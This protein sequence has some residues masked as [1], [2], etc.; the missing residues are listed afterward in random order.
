MLKK[1]ICFFKGH[2]PKTYWYW[3]DVS[4][5]TGEYLYKEKVYWSECDRCKKNLGIILK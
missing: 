5:T 1:I 4:A 3:C 2:I